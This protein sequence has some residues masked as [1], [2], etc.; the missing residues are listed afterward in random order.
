MV[1]DHLATFRIIRADHSDLYLCSPCTD[2]FKRTAPAWLIRRVEEYPRA[3]LDCEHC[4][5]DPEGLDTD[6]TSTDADRIQQL[7]EQLL[8]SP[9]RE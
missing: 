6:P 3:D 1:A 5:Y 7:A 9:P 8:P 4:E 2:D